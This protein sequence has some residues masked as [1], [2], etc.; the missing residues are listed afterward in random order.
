[1]IKDFGDYYLIADG[2]YKSIFI[3]SE[4]NDFYLKIN[5]DGC[6]AERLNS[7]DPLEILGVD[8]E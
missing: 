2:L 4:K 3:S 5:D 1:M 8:E 7:D 6:I